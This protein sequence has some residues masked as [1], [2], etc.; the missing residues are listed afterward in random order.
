MFAGYRNLTVKHKLQVIIMASVGAAL[1]LAGAGNVIQI[2]IGLRN[3]MRADLE[4]LAEVLASNSTAPLMFDDS[5]AAEE[6]LDGLR[7]KRP[8]VAAA[9]FTNDGKVLA[10]YRRD[11]HSAAPP[12]FLRDRSILNGDHL[13]VY[14]TAALKGQS[15]GVIFLEADSTTLD[16]RVAGAFWTA[17]LIA[18]LTMLPALAL[19]ARL[20]RG[21]SEPIAH[22]ASVAARVS[23][24]RNYSIR[25]FKLADDDLG[26]LIDTFNGMLSE[27]QSRDAPCCV[28]R[29]I[30]NTRWRREPPNWCL[31]KTAPKPPTAPR[32]NFWRT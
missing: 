32:A 19:A 6:I 5:R 15:E 10:E 26:R 29:T 24:E 7:A 14:R 1:L 4:A 28:L 2:R 22:L 31:P 3:D 23:D 13:L 9:L 25:A 21:V 18:L 20:Q 30:L 8:I 11:G 12:P 27:I 16:A 17:L